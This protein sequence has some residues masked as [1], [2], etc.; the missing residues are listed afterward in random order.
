MSL[1]PHSQLT[2]VSSY[3]ETEPIDPEGTLGSTWF[4]NGVVRLETNIAPHS[5]LEILQE[6][7]KGLGRDLN[8]RNGPRTMD[9]DI[10]FFGQQVMTQP[11]LTIPHPRLHLRR[12]VLA[13]L[14]EIV[15]DWHHPILNRSVK[16]LLD[17]VDDSSHVQKLDII[18][19][20]RYGSPPSCSKP[21]S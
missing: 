3:Y 20:S 13:P 16:E 15:P 10:L 17:H 19:G 8:Q 7:E 14:A 2:G 6:T 21:S 5:L 18:P 1:L 9:F 12:F 4:F 11:G